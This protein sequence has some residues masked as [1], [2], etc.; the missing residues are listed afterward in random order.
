LTKEKTEKLQILLKEFKDVFALTY[1]DLNNIL[2][3][4]AQQR[5]E[6]IRYLNTTSTSSK[7]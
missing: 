6:V 2:P 4:L 3:E 7:V 1:K 5:I